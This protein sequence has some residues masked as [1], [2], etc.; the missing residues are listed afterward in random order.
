MLPA[1]NWMTYNL[2]PRMPFL[3]SGLLF[4]L[5]PLGLGGVFFF[6]TTIKPDLHRRLPREKYLGIVIGAICL[7]WSAGQALPML[8]GGL[9]KFQPLI[10]LLVPTVTVL[11]FFFLNFIF[12][13][14]L[15]GLMMLSATHMLHQAFIHHP[16][17]RPVFSL[18]CYI[19]AVA[20][21]VALALPW[22]F[23]DLL[24]KCSEE[25]VWRK[26]LGAGCWGMGILIVLF[27]LL[28]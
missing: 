10:K 14:A 21:M 6:G 8:E 23:R 13:R 20:G 7:T 11:S 22:Y 28:G 16:P 9:A 4:A 15:G 19:I 5:I 18:A 2:E 1:C 25:A 27:A 24:E 12:T 3:F 17:C 26:G